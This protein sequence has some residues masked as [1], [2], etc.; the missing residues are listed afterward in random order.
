MSRVCWQIYALTAFCAYVGMVS[1]RLRIQGESWINYLVGPRYVW[2]STLLLFGFFGSF[3]SC[4]RLDS[5]WLAAALG[6]LVTGMC[7]G[8]NIVYQLD[9]LPK[10]WPALTLSDEQAWRDVATMTNELRRAD[11]PVPDLSLQI[12]GGEKPPMVRQYEPMLR[13]LAGVKADEPLRWV[14]SGEI[15]PAMWQDMKSKSPTLARL[16]SLVF[17]EQDDLARQATAELAEEQ[18]RGPRG[19]SLLTAA[20]LKDVTFDHVKAH[21]NLN[22]DI[23]VNGIPRK[24]VWINAPTGLTYH[25][26][27]L[28]THPALHVY[29]A[30][31]PLIYT[32]A[33]A[34]GAT[35]QVSVGFDGQTEQLADIYLNPIAHPE[36]RRWTPLDVDL[37]KYAG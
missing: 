24:S 15:T 7:I 26:V 5:R 3:A 19:A 29:M 20:V 13:K 21:P 14:H 35:F 25:H 8:S 16:S 9:V 2:P 6:L 36:L 22:V 10:V 17:A 23:A 11:L 37:S 34:D 28:G 18:Q 31:H 1:L 12:L 4:F 32:D 33:N 27:A 30:I